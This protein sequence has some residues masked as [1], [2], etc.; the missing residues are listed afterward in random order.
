MSEQDFFNN[1]INNLEHH[2][3]KYINELNNITDIP[4]ETLIDIFQHSDIKNPLKIQITGKCLGKKGNSTDKECIALIKSGARKGAPCG[5]KVSTKSISESYCGTHYKLE[6][7]KDKDNEI[8]GLLFRLNKWNNYTFGDTGLVLKS[9]KE[10]KIIGKQTI[11]GVI[12]DLSEDDIA[13]CKMR[14][15]KFIKNYSSNN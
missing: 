4:K 5:K 1:F 11:D 6:D 14:K 3:I 8:D 9:D 13:L 10:K 12:V 7:K 15:L 2:I